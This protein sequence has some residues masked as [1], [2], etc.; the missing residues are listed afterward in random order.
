M[1]FRGQDLALQCKACLQ[2]ECIHK[3]SRNYDGTTVPVLAA[4]YRTPIHIES[5]PISGLSES[6]LFVVRVP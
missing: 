5:A 2:V 4:C 1:E 6:L 3:G